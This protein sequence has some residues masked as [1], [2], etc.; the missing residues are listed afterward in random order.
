VSENA[1]P[2]SAIIV[3][4]RKH[5]LLLLDDC[6]YALQATIPHL[7]NDR[8]G[9]M[10]KSDKYSEFEA[11]LEEQRHGIKRSLSQIE[12]AGAETALDRCHSGF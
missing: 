7:S 4:F 1:G 5:T 2:D 6:L 12:K 9:H 11:Y 3:A 8:A 10:A